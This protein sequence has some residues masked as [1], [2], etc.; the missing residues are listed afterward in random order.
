M[1]QFAN[2]N[3][4]PSQKKPKINRRTGR[5]KKQKKGNKNCDR[6]KQNGICEK[7]LE[8]NPNQPTDVATDHECDSTK[9]VNIDEII[10]EKTYQDVPDTNREEIDILLNNH[11]YLKEIAPHDCFDWDHEDHSPVYNDYYPVFHSDNGYTSEEEFD[12]NNFNDRHYYTS[13]DIIEQDKE[14][15]KYDSTDD[16]PITQQDNISK[17]NDI[18]PFIYINYEDN[19]NN[20]N[21]PFETKVNSKEENDDIKL[22]TS[23]EEIQFKTPPAL[24]FPDFKTEM[25]NKENV[26][27]KIEIN[28]Q[29]NNEA[30]NKY[31]NSKMSSYSDTKKAA[32]NEKS[33][34]VVDQNEVETVFG[35]SKVVIYG[36]PTN[37]GDLCMDVINASNYGD[38]ENNFHHPNAEKTTIV[39]AKSLPYPI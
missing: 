22:K 14:R 38:E 23:S 6:N 36:A 7:N 4:I 15:K 25:I 21:E 39:I 28:Y 20:E 19:E 24:D 18:N 1:Q 8:S 12:W 31:E 17:P 33:N 13:S 37:N 16:G 32:S 11:E 34:K 26:I 5:R 3:L 30:I 29:P 35:H 27:P 2:E 9:T 10:I